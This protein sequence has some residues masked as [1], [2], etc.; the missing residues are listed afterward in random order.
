MNM[1]EEKQKI[2]EMLEGQ[3]ITVAE[4]MGLLDAIDEAPSQPQVAGAADGKKFLRIR[5][6]G[7]KTKKV[8]VNIPLGLVKVASKFAG[9]GMG[10]IPEEARKEMEQK[11][12]NLAQLDLE[13]VVHLISQGLVEEK[14]VDI[15][16]DDPKEGPM[17]VEVYVE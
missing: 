16:I 10:F 6:S 17:K 8:N 5:V 14:L 12:I 13:E 2:L 3:K 15:D 7:E 4:A 11:G 9:F 1:N